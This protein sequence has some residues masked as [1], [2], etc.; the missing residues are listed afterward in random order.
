MGYRYLEGLTQA[1]VAFRAEGTD[2]AEMFRAAWQATLELMLPSASALEARERRRIALANPEVEMLLFDFLG[3]LV[4]HKDAEGLL[5]R[6]E[7]L[8]V[9]GSPGAY[10]LEAQ[11]AGEAADPARHELGTDVKAV[12]LHRFSV[13]RSPGG[14]AATVILDV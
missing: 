8:T 1:D 9:E 4:Y 6:L 11:A 14:W 2:L 12:T 3:E 5:L 10:R 7:S 13:E